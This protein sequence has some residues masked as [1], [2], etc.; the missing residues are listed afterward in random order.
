MCVC[1][2]VCVCVCWEGGGGD[3]DHRKG[4]RGDNRDHRN[5]VYFD[6]SLDDHDLCLRCQLYEKPE[7]SVLIFL[8]MSQL[9]WMKFSV[10]QQ[11]VCLL[12]LMPNLFH[13]ID[14]QGRELCFWDCKKCALNI[15]LHVDT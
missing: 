5:I 9:M 2:C 4:E 14:G 3:R 12:K 13:V 10:L 11:P 6:K 1:V 7:T 15:G 8:L